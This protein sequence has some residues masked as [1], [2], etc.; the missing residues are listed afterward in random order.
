M[1]RKLRRTKTRTVVTLRELGI[2][3]RLS[4]ITGWHP[5]TCEFERQQSPRWSTYREYLDDYAAVRDEML[6]WR[7]AQPDDYAEELFRRVAADSRGDVEVIGRAVWV[8][9]YPDFTK[10]MLEARGPHA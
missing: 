7:A 6:A 5:P 3:A 10:W 4:F 9:K 8:W 2:P 1:P